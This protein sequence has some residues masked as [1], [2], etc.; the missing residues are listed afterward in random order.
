MLKNWNEL[1]EY[2]RT[3]EVRPYYDLLQRKKLSLFFKRVF[4]IVVSLIMIILCSPI[5]L[6]ISILIVK[7]SKGGVFYRQERV[8][9]Y[10]RVF[11]IFKF[12]TMVQNANQIGTQVTVSNDSRIT[13]IGSKLRNCRLDELPQLFNIF[14]G[15]MTFVGTRPE[16]VHYVKSYTNEMYATLLLPAGVTSEASIE[17][18]DEA[19]LLDQADDVDSVYINEVLPEKMKYNLNSIK[20]FSFFKEIATMFRTVFA[21]F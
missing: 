7:D 17:Y 1:P 4:D 10:G 12:R 16:S 14:L 20:E 3:D 2:M 5:L 19:D 21:V 9:Q 18:K 15:D 13:K 8:T 11:R 6:I